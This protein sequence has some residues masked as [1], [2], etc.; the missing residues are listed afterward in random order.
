M[1]VYV[2]ARIIQGDF[3]AW[4]TAVSSKNK[5]AICSAVDQLEADANTAVNSAR[6]WR[7]AAA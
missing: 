3:D 6:A 2:F 7:W 4:R 1:D 5:A